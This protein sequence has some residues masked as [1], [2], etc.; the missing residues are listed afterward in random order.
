MTSTTYP[1]LPDAPPGPSEDAILGEILAEAAR[2]GIST[3]T[4]QRQAGISKNIFWRIRRRERHLELTHFLDLCRVVGKGPT[5][6]IQ[7]AELNAL[8]Q[9]EAAHGRPL[10]AIP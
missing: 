2:Q 1:R 10:T 4:L 8:R 3:S 6:I 5:E 7:Q 9:M